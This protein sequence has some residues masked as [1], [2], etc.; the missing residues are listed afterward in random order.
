MTRLFIQFYVGVL[1]V[2]VLAWYI[3]GVVLKRRVDAEW[4]RVV[5][6]AHGGGARLVASELDSAPAENREQ[7]LNSIRERFAYSVEVVPVAEL[8]TSVQRQLSDASVVA[9]SH[10]EEQRHVVVAALA[11]GSEVVRLGPFPNYDLKEIEDSLGGW[12]RLTAEQLSATA[13]IEREVVLKGIQEQFNIPI[14]IAGREELPDYPK[15]RIVRGE[16]IVF[17]RPGVRANGL[18]YSATPLANENEIVQFG[19]FP[20]FEPKEEKAA[21]T[22]LALVLLPAAFAIAL[23]LRPV[24]R[25]LRRLEHAAKTIAA[26]DLSARVDERRVRSA[27]PLAQAFNNMANRTESMVRAQQEL[28]QAVSHELRTPL[29][30]IHFAIDLIRAARDSEQREERLDSLEAS[31]QEL[32]ELVGELL[33]YVRMETSEPKL[34]LEEVPLRPLVEELV[35]KQSPLHPATVF[36]VADSLDDQLIVRGDRAGLHRVMGNIIANAGRFAR[37]RVVINAQET[38][39]GIVVDV[40]DDG[41]GIAVADRE[42]VFDPFVRLG[43]SGNGVGLGLALVQRIVAGHGGA[44][45]IEESPLGGCRVRT[46]WPG[47]DNQLPAAVEPFTGESVTA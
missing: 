35:E 27:K 3:H 13:P 5:E 12:M 45:R 40:D 14:V 17:Y 1:I 32:D 8:P 6:E 23:L 19:P 39:D 43:D 26:G 11:N 25:Q 44:V 37:S 29:S 30:R 16:S 7:L 36:E 15:G 38:A 18:W 22:T 33:R 24:A 34:E 4:I 21:T 41:P 9:Y 31:A 20:S 46:T 28:L 2:L 10:A 42:R 47:L